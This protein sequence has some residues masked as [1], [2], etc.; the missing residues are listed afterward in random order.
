MKEI[1]NILIK[2]KVFVIPYL[3]FC[4]ISV[5]FLLTYD[6]TE[7]HIFINKYHNFSFDF[8]FKYW[9]H[10]GHGILAV[11]ITLVFLFIRYK[12]AVMFA[13]SSFMTAITV[14]FLKRIIFAD[15]FRPKF[16]FQYFYKGN[17]NLHFVKGADPGTLFSF[18][19]GH[20]ASAFV[21]FFLLSIIVKNQ[22]LKLI[23][24][25]IAL[26]ATFSRVYLSWHFLGDIFA[27]SLIGFL[28]TLIAY[29]YINKCDKSW[30]SRSLLSKKIK[31]DI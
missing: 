8:F 19:S 28:I 12:W 15:C 1:L 10:L 2:N 13:V 25:I 5:Y 29:Y 9:T 21:V 7:I 17:Y 18:P 26:S 27:G 20:S 16:V 14:Q 24:F 6:K 22:M 11:L 30:L 31:S 23:F 3:I 4:L